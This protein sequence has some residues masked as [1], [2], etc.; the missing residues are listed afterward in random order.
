MMI[1]GMTQNEAIIDHCLRTKW[2]QNSN[3]KDN[4]AE[5]QQKTFYIRLE[6]PRKN[7]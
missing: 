7:K 1:K 3:N 6:Q 5:T 4:K 2:Q